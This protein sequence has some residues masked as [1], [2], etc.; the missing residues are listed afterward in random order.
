VKLNAPARNGATRKAL[1][2]TAGKKLSRKALKGLLLAAFCVY[3][4]PGGIS[5]WESIGPAA[6]G[7]QVSPNDPR[8]IERVVAAGK[9][10]IWVT[11]GRET[12]WTTED[13]GRT[14]KPVDTVF[15]R[16]EMGGIQFLD[17]RTGWVFGAVGS[18]AFIAS[19]TDGGKK[20][21]ITHVASDIR[22]S[23]FSD[24]GFLGKRNGVAVGGGEFDGLPGSLV[25]ITHDGGSNWKNIRVKTDDPQSVLKRVCYLSKTQLWASGGKSIYQS[26]DGGTTWILRHREPDAVDLAGLAVVEGGVFAA[27]GWGLVLRSRDGTNWDKLKLPEIFAKQYVNSV[28]FSD[29]KHGWVCGDHGM[30]L[31]TQDGGETWQQEASGRTELLRFVSVIGT[32]V[33]AVGDN[34]TVIRRPL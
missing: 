9:R 31:S 5:A 11:T 29:A 12:A 16:A 26:A 32:Q 17:D 13:G 21:D 7:Q 34:L 14:W 6:T 19:T 1:A 24:V 15:T 23:V 25:A 4:G 2:R 10:A 27:G 33:F 30:I 3:A 8:N 28:A 22:N 20:W 18:K